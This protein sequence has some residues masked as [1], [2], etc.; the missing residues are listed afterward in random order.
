MHVPVN[1]EY[2]LRVDS[3]V[4]TEHIRSISKRRFFSQGNSPMLM[5]KL[6][7]YKMIEVENAIRL[8]LGMT[9]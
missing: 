7:S 2:G 1:R 4:L 5:G 6:P 9:S 3:Y 8:Q